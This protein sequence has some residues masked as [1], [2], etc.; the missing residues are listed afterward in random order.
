MDTKLPRIWSAVIVLAT[1]LVPVASLAQQPCGLVGGPGWTNTLFQTVGGITYLTGTAW[2]PNCHEVV[3]GPVIRDGTN[4]TQVIY[5]VDGVLC[6]AI[7]LDC[8]DCSYVNEHVSVMGA[9]QAGNYV[10]HVW[11]WLLWAD[12]V[13]PTL[14]PL[15]DL[16][17]TVPDSSSGTLAWALNT[18]GP[19][20][21]LAVNGVPGVRYV[22]QASATLTNWTAVVTN[23]GGPF[24]WSEPISKQPTNRFY[25]VMIVGP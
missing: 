17:F 10:L 2:L 13:N 16:G 22:I 9:L 3:A 18:N 20:F 5:E 24:V 14:S 11:S 21:R 15:E 7:C 8:I 6:G 25:R 4:L 23:Y 19:S 1:A 12:P